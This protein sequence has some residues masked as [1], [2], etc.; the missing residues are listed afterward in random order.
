[1]N[2]P[3]PRLPAFYGHGIAQGPLKPIGII[4]EYSLLQ[5]SSLGFGYNIN[6]IVQQMSLQ[7]QEDQ[8]PNS[9]DNLSQT[10]PMDIE[11]C[12][13]NTRCLSKQNISNQHEIMEISEHS[14]DIC[15]AQNTFT[16]PKHST[17]NVQC[18][19]SPMQTHQTNSDNVVQKNSSFQRTSTPVQRSC[20][21][22]LNLPCNS[23][24]NWNYET[25]CF[26]YYENGCY[27]ECRFVNPCDIEDFM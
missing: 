1:M 20:P 6:P 24:P 25:D 2:Y 5:Q 16:V 9:P 18:F 15:S 27:N 10:C 12:Q 17:L 19:Q 8:I 3:S 11:N 26:S 23:Y 13:I 21:P 22:L 4:S 14:A 7:I